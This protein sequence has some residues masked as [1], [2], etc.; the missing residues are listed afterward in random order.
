[1]D[2]FER[3]TSSCASLIIL[4]RAWY[5]RL[6]YLRFLRVASF[7]YAIFSLRA[8]FRGLRRRL[9]ISFYVSDYIRDRGVLI[10]GLR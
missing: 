10:A 3:P 8:I 1:M 2:T 6:A 4:I 5:A 9:E 7:E